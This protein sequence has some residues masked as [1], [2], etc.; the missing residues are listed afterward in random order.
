MD[1]QQVHL[2]GGPYVTADGVRLQVPHGSRRLLAFV[3]LRPG[4]AERPYT[5]G[6]LW[7][8]GDDL[9]ASSNLRSALWRLRRAGIDVLLADKWSIWLAEGVEVDLHRTAAWAGRLIHGTA[10]PADLSAA[11]LPADALDL[12]PGWYDDWVII[13]RERMRQRVLHGLEALSRV[14]ADQ[15]RHADAVDVAYRAVADEPLRESA[16]RT[17]IEAYLAQGNRVEA[18]RIF[19]DYAA[20]VRGQLGVDP[21]PSLT[22]LIIGPARGYQVGVANPAGSAMASIAGRSPLPG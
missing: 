3:A 2:F 21:S 6:I 14:L 16:Q 15:G 7:P 9:R 19:T 11:E 13:E 20:R 17:L 8:T 1:V 18:R 10:E 12:L 5:A 4:R 22:E